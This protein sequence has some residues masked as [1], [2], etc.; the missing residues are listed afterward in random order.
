MK[1]KSLMIIAAVVLLVSG[2]ALSGWGPVLMPLYGASEIPD[3]V[4]SDEAAMTVWAGISFL[5]LFGAALFGVGVVSLFT[6]RLSSAEAQKAVS[7]SLFAA[8]V[9]I[10][11]VA[12]I[13]QIAIWSTTVGWVTVSLLLLVALGYGYLG[14]AES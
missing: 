1:Y 2:F 3:P 10:F 14:L 5:R 6:H 12:L 4:A 8:M 11:A 7:R 13:Q 9:G